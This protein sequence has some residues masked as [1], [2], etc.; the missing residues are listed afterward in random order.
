MKKKISNNDNKTHAHLTEFEETIEDL[1]DMGVH[2]KQ[3]I[4]YYAAL[5]GGAHER[6]E[7]LH[8]IHKKMDMN[9]KTTLA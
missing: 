6:L 8:N 9:W 3:D 5:S 1:N 4:K 2:V 7:I